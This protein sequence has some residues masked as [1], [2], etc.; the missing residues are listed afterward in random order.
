MTS[1]GA[2]PGWRRDGCV[3][4]VPPAV[5]GGAS[6]ADPIARTPQAG[7]GYGLPIS[8][9]YAKYFQGDLQLFSMEGFGTDAVIYLKVGANP[10]PPPPQGDP[11]GSGGGAHLSA[12]SHRRSPR[13]RWSGCRCT[14]S[15]RGGTTR[16]ARRGG[17]G[18]CP[19]PS[20]RT[21]PPT[22]CHRAGGTAGT[23]PRWH[24]GMGAGGGRGVLW[25]GGGSPRCPPTHQPRCTPRGGHSPVGSEGPPTP[26]PKPV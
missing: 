9:L 10:T 18:A 13:T 16:P 3:H 2:A 25:E 15:L 5:P 19:A 12:L 8:R 23:P 26:P 14:T 1:G 6:G 4:T 17:I 11:F 7:F 24:C 21:P 22:V 20:P